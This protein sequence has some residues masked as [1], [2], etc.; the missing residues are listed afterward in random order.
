MRLYKIENGE[1]KLYFSQKN[2]VARTIGI[3][4]GNLNYYM[5]KGSYKNWKISLCEDNVMSA[6]IDKYIQ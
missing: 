6:E 5:N 1:E 2:Y 3:D 4:A